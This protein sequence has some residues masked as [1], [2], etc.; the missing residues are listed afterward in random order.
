MKEITSLDTLMNGA[1]NERFNSEMRKL[2]EN[3]YDPNTDPI[4]KRKLVMTLS[5]QPSANR[6]SA[7]IESDVKIVLAPPVPHKQTIFIAQTDDGRVH[8]VENNGQLPGQVDMDGGVN[9]PCEAYFG[10]ASEIPAVI[11]FNKRE[12]K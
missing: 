12:A 11:E 8:A 3:I 6:D 10:D 9:E 5:I 1:L 7:Q 4:K 2:L